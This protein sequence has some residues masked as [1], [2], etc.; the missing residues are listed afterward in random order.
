[1]IKQKPKTI[2]GQTDKKLQ[3]F[4]ALKNTARPPKGWV[5]AIRS[6]MKMSLRQLGE[7]LDVTPQSIKE[8]ETREKNGTVTIDALEKA[9]KALN[10][11]LVYGFIPQEGSINEM[12]ENQ[13]HKVATRLINLTAAKLKPAVGETAEERK[14][15]AIEELTEELI[16]TM[17]RYLWD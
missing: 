11:K 13:A 9:G 4:A 8:L 2:T 10:M 5:N 7:R 17:P 14:E 6:G 15:R 1:M 3:E 16:R 12:I